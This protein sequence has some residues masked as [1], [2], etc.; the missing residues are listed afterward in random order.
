M[1]YTGHFVVFIFAKTIFLPNNMLKLAQEMSLINCTREASIP[2][3]HSQD[4]TQRE[5]F[6]ADFL[7]YSQIPPKLFPSRTLQI[8][9]P[10]SSF[11]SNRHPN[12]SATPLL[13]KVL[14][15]YTKITR[16]LGKVPVTDGRGWYH[17]RLVTKS[18]CQRLCPLI[19]LRKLSSIFLVL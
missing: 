10:Y 13:Q 11:H 3:S 7:I 1:N 5:R 12:P 16:N 18:L 14:K 17:Y 2:I 9:L 4:I 6:L 19:F 15:P 8:I